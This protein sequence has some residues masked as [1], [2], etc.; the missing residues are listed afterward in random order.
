MPKIPKLI[1]TIVKTAWSRM[2]ITVTVIEKEQL[3][4][5]LLR[6]R[7]S[8]DLSNSKYEVGQAILMQISDTEYRNYTPSIFNTKEGYFD[9]VFH[10]KSKGPATLFFKE[11]EVGKQLTTSLPRGLNIY[12]E[13]VY[14]HFFY[15]DDTCIGVCQALQEMMNKN[16]HKLEGL[17]EIER[18]ATPYANEHIPYIE[19]ISKSQDNELY[20]AVDYLDSIDTYRWNKLIHGQF[21]L[22]GNG[23][24]IQKFRKALRAKGVSANNIIVQPFW[25]QGKV[26][27]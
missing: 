1:G 17:L 25:V 22:M 14:Y 8:G 3:T 21:Y 2:F 13:N 18:E 19:Y 9:V 7:F 26:G 16:N 10:Q 23:K 5:E 15:G 12:D 27:L 24:K 11:I 4:N 20:P 6:I